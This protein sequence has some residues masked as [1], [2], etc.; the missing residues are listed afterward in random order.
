MSLCFFMRFTKWEWRVCHEI[1]YNFRCKTRD[2][3]NF[4]KMIYN[5][6]K[7]CRYFF[8]FFNNRKNLGVNEYWC[9]LKKLVIDYGWYLIDSIF[10]ILMKKDS[11]V[12]FLNLK[13]TKKKEIN[14][15]LIYMQKNLFM[16]PTT[17]LILSVLNNIC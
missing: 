1:F 4:L 6:D 2:T 12:I 15:F 8:F 14:Q 7:K 9:L 11:Q 13:K 10:L 16:H 3:M 17:F 5:R